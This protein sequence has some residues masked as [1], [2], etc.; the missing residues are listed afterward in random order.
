MSHPQRQRQDQRR[1]HKYPT[2]APPKGSHCRCLQ[3]IARLMRVY[4]RFIS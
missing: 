4:T 2:A 3:P 1:P